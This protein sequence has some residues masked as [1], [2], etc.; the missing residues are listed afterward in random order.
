MSLSSEATFSYFLFFKYYL[1]LL[2]YPCLSSG[3]DPYLKEAETC[4]FLL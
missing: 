4:L 1:K 2:F 3:I